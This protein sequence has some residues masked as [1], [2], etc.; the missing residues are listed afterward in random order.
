MGFHKRY[1]DDQQVIDIYEESGVKGVRE[2]YTKGV[3]ALITSGELSQ[4][5]EEIIHSNEI[6]EE[7]KDD[8]LAMI[9]QI[10]SLKRKAYEDEKTTTSS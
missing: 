9:F 5:A 2:W 6:V 4:Q 8:H 1:I 3:D 7:E 10:A